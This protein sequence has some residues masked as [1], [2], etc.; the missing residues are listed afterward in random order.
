MMG[1]GG[2]WAVVPVKTLGLAKQ[3]LAGALAPGNRVG[4]AR[5]MLTDVLD[6]LSGASG[7]AGILVVTVDPEAQA[8]ARRSGARISEADA[9]SGHT[10]AVAAAAARL[11]VEGAAAMLALPSDIPAATPREIEGLLPHDPAARGVTLVPSRDG[12]GTNAVVTSPPTS[13]CLAFGPGSFARHVTNARAAGV[14]PRILRPPGIG[15]DIDRP[16][17]LVA[18]LAVARDTSTRRFC[19]AH[20]AGAAQRSEAE[21]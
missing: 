15:L 12:E 18:F 14:E 2:I 13:L 5:A 3:R 21:A 1:R 11:E 4:L 17:D 9:C 10:A 19:L 20:L 16:E 7:L 8:I 6:A